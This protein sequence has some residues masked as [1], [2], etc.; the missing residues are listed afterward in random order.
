MTK[1]KINIQIFNWGPCVVRMK[2]SDAFKKMLLHEAK[3]NKQ[4]YT[5]KLAGILDKETGYSEQSKAKIIPH[6]SQCLGV[7]DQA[8]EQYINKKYEKKPEYILSALWINW[9]APYKSDCTRISVSGNV[10][11]SA[12][13]NNITKFAPK[14]LDS[15]KKEQEEKEYLKEL[16]KKL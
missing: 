11:D 13:L 15:K 7:Y 16:K 12:P 4:D 14:Y 8:F 3:G 9:V 1:Q 5:S 2:I 10:H 6:L